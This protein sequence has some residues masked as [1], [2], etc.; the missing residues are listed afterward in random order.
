MKIKCPK[1]QNPSEYHNKNPYRPFC[2]RA[3]KDDDVIQWAE[4]RYTISR[5]LSA[6]DQIDESFFDSGEDE[7]LDS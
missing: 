6:E 7:D 3:C 5:E 4:E 1:C 2:S